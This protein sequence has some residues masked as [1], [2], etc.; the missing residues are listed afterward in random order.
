MK[1]STAER[2]EGQRE[3]GQCPGGEGAGCLSTE[4]KQVEVIFWFWLE[5]REDVNQ[6]LLEDV[7]ER[8]ATAVF[9]KVGNVYR[10][11]SLVK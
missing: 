1:Q 4:Q 3:W 2:V 9:L 11:L 6:E 7:K 8:A 5:D 10:E